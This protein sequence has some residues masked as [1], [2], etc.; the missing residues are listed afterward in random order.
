[1]DRSSG[2]DPVECVMTTGS[3]TRRSTHARTPSTIERDLKHSQTR[4]ASV[5]STI[6]GFVDRLRQN[7]DAFGLIS[8][9]STEITEPML[10][11]DNA[12]I[13][14]DRHRYMFTGFTDGLVADDVHYNGVGA[15]FIA[16]RYYSVLED[17]F[18]VP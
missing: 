3:D 15:Q 10:N 5:F 1:M 6:D 14:G 8:S 9:Q 18:Q 12:L 16:D 4:F 11:R 2:R 7:I 17:A 13:S